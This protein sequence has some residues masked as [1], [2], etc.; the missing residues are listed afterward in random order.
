MPDVLIVEDNAINRKLITVLLDRAGYSHGVAEN[1]KQALQ[2][3]D[4]DTFRLVLMDLM[5]P[6][7]N[8]HETIAAIRESARHRHLPIIA[9]TANGTHDEEVRCRAAGCD[10]YIAK[11]Y[12]KHRI[13]SLI[14]SLMPKQAAVA[15]GA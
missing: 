13:L 4:K 12:A 11:P 10:G 6:V 14:A 15:Q 1:G 7:M 9:V 2:H 8:G 3:L 5:M